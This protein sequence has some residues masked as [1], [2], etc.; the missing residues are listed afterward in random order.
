M[1]RNF[2][3]LR[4][5]P[6]PS[7]G[8]SLAQALAEFVVGGGDVVVLLHQALA[9]LQQHTGAVA[10]ALWEHTPQGG[11]QV[12][13]SLGPLPAEALAAS[14]LAWDAALA[15]GLAGGASLGLALE[16]WLLPAQ[17]LVV[18]GE[19]I[20]LSATEAEL[21]AVATT[22]AAGLGHHHTR[23]RARVLFD[24]SLTHK[25]LYTIDERVVA[26][27]TL[28]LANIGI[29]PDNLPQLIGKHLSETPWWPLLAERAEELR[30]YWQR[31][32]AGEVVSFEVSLEVRGTTL[33]SATTYSPIVNHAGQTVLV[34][35]EGHDIT[36]F[37]ETEQELQRANAV[38]RQFLSNM[39]HELRTPLNA[40]MGFNE[41]LQGQFF[42]LLNAQQLEY[43]GEIHHAATHMLELVNDILDVSQIEDG[44][45]KIERQP[46]NLIAIANASVNLMQNRARKTGLRLGLQVPVMPANPILF[47][48][49]RK[50][51]QVILNLISNSI[52]F[53][54]SGG[55]IDIV[56]TQDESEITVGIIDTGIGIDSSHL[57]QLFEHFTQLDSGNTRKHDGLGVGLS[58]AQTYMRLHGGYISVT[59]ELGQGSCFVLHFPL[60]H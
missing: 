35:V 9:E 21:S 57:S 18:Y 58:I 33:Y 13:A 59:S 28:A 40:I 52:K 49:G 51:K 30:D 38:K 12:V 15:A 41:L 6:L 16:R 27:N 54:P 8:L 17:L 25:V 53:T 34:L 37:R 56:I 44:T 3:S 50:I 26:A 29:R 60:E 23:E 39:S 43:L 14:T 47:L 22:I 1:L 55:R 32:C 20:E 4:N 45:L 36:R 31:T 5:P 19:T 7:P 46:Q 11:C 2:M 48:D 10:V 24:Q 42:G